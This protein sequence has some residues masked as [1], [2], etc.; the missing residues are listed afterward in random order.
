MSVRYSASADAAAGPHAVQM[1]GD[2]VD[3]GRAAR[4]AGCLALRFCAGP[5]DAGFVGEHD[6]LD[7]VAQAELGQHAGDVGLDRR[8]ARR[9]AARRSRRSRGRARRARGSRSSRAVS[10]S[11]PAAASAA[12]GRS[13]TKDSISRRVTDGES[14]ESPCGDRCGSRRA[15]CSGGDV[16]EQE[17]AGAGMQRVEHVLVEVEGGEHQH[18]WRARS[19]R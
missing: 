1:L 17:A 2:H 15:S 4:W 11:R 18:A 14:S 16:L 6:G 19:R 13:R 7:A 12:V 9:R 3:R 8:A 5:D 10:S